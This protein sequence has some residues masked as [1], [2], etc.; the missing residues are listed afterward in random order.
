M[1]LYSTMGYTYFGVLSAGFL[2]DVGLPISLVG[3]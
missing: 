1:P 3:N 2:E